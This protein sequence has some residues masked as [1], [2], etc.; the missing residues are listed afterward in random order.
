MSMTRYEVL[1]YES[2]WDGSYRI[3][4]VRTASGDAPPSPPIL[5][6]TGINHVLFWTVEVDAENEEQ[7]KRRAVG[8]LRAHADRHRVV[9][10]T[11]EEGGVR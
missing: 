4:Q 3:G 9:L 10:T 2:D 6:V 1:F 7:A 8:V 5:S 11:S